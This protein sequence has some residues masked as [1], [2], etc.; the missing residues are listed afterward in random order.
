M[1]IMNIASCFGVAYQAAFTPKNISS[2]FKETGIWPFNKDIFTTDDFEGAYVTDRPLQQQASA[3]IELP[4]SSVATSVAP[5][6]SV[7]NI[8]EAISTTARQASPPSDN[9]SL[10]DKSTMCVSAV[11]ALGSCIPPQVQCTSTSCDLAEQSAITSAPRVASPEEI[12]P[13]PKAGNRKVTNSKVCRRKGDTRI[14]TDTPVKLQVQRDAE[15]R[16]AK[17]TKKRKLFPIGNKDNTEGTAQGKGIPQKQRNTKTKKKTARSGCRSKKMACQINDKTSSDHC[18]AC[19]VL[20]GEKTDSKCDEDWFQC[21]VCNK[22][23]HDSCA[24]NFGILDVDDIFTCR[25]CVA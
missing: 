15:A 3:S 6:N 21:S 12:R 5:D 10:A 4:T 2:A 22:W 16:L 14:L 8:G 9:Q 11:A 24:Q 25:N 17:S 20:Y 23:F 1:T 19:G 7:A 13:F 18:A